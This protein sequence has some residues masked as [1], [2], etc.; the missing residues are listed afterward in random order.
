MSFNDSVAFL[1]KSLQGV[2]LRQQAISH[3]LANQSTPGYRARDV[4][5]Q[6]ALKDALR[7]DGVDTL[8]FRIVEQEGNEVNAEGNNVNLEREWQNMEENRLFHEMFSRA[9]GRRFR[10][11][12][13]AIRGQ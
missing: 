12:V 3:N 2:M 4:D 8:R 5:F 7:S 13:R 6:G 10:T 11:M 9:L 1:E